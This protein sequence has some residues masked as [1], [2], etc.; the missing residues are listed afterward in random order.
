MDSP[1]DGQAMGDDE[2]RGTPWCNLRAHAASSH[3]HVM[4]S[5]PVVMAYIYRVSTVRQGFI[6]EVL[7]NDWQVMGA[8]FLKV[9]PC[10]LSEMR[11]GRNG[12]PQGP[13]SATGHRTALLFCVQSGRSDAHASTATGA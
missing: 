12:K 6:A 13:C 8:A 5:T 7:I 3:C 2:C 10:K 4:N 9:V 11:R 1:F